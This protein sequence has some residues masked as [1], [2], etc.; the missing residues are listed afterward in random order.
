MPG[1][2][3][4][5]DWAIV[6]AY[7]A[8]SI[9]VGARFAK[10]AG[11]N[12]EEYF[13]S[14]RRLPWWVAGT[15]MVAT[16]F[17][18][19]TPLA[20]S[21]WV[22]EY[23]IWKNWAWWCFAVNG[24]LQVFLFSRWWR[25]GNV[26]TKAEMVELRY[27]AG[28]QLLRGVLGIL[29]ATV[30]NTIIMSWV[31]LA[32]MKILGVLF[33]V[34]PLRALIVASLIA[35][36]Y[37]W[38]AGFWGVV[39]TDMVQF[40]MAMTG[41]IVLAT[42]AWNAVGGS[43]AI[44]QAASD[45]ILSPETLALM[46]PPGPGGLFDA[47]Y[48]T[49]SFAAA[50]V[51]LGFSWWAAESVD[52]SGTIVQRI[53]ASRDDRQGML[54]VL[55][56]NLAHYALRPWCWI[57]V[58]LASLLVLP[59]IEVTAPAPGTIVSRSETEIVFKP[60]MED[61]APITL[62]LD[63]APAQADWKPFPTDAAAK[64]NRVEEGEVL[65]RTDPERAYIVMARR[66]LPIGLLGLVAASLLAAFM[67]TIDTHVNLASSFFVNDV[68]R[69]FIV[70]DAPAGEYVLVAKLASVAALAIAGLFAWQADSIV[71]L[72]M[73]FWALLGG[74]GPI[75]LL[76]WLWWRIRP[77]TEV[78]AMLASLVTT[79]TLTIGDFA[80]PDSALSPGGALAPEGRLLIVV[81]VS[82]TAAFVALFLTK[83]PAPENLVP[84]Y[85]RVRPLGFWGPVRELCHDLPPSRDLA[86]AVVGSLG[87]LALIFGATLGL[88]Y[89]F[90]A[91]TGPALISLTVLLAGGVAV[92]WALLRLR[93]QPASR[94]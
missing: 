29:H 88:G 17:A 25:R 28:S 18:A 19:D 12:V 23:G 6:L 75:Y 77:S 93:T 22:R 62:A 57:L 42:L 38:F 74:V 83:K 8:F 53:C 50:A 86:P 51:Y 33:E 64:G 7:I 15:S 26:M 10:R 79:V 68:Y 85:T 61:A 3:H 66:Y 39:V 90:L 71:D 76:R 49:V 31:L 81:A 92:A 73:F 32:A 67:S 54:A 11:Q 9:W 69:R 37:S 70:P 78:T 41:A 1:P 87:G 89:L 55:W 46:P 4:A 40:A 48:W 2:L 27:G 5:V 60:S 13:L 20:I 52:G 30:I 65:A 56:Y 82:L 36:L 45:G 91:R 94:P 72:F 34:E 43:A 24:V 14:G 16:S 80:F 58:G 84:F 44:A 35:L 63:R 59:K 21:G 47:S